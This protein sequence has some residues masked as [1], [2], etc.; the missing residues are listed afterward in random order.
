MI[1]GI[2]FDKDGT[3]FDF[4]ASWGRW[5][6]GF[7]AQLARDQTHAATLAQAIGYLPQSNSF[8]PDSR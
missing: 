6:S 7:I 2:V 5:A 8:R 1:R 4:R 3:L